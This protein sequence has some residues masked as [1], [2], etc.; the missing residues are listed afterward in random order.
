MRVDQTKMSL[1]WASRIDEDRPSDVRI[2]AKEKVDSER[3]IVWTTDERFEREYKWNRR[4]PR[5]EN[6]PLE[7]RENHP[8]RNSPRRFCFE[9]SSFQSMKIVIDRTDRF[10]R[11][12]STEKRSL[13][14]SIVLSNAPFTFNRFCSLSWLL[15]QGRVGWISKIR[16]F[17]LR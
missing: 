16:G 17:K 4:F 10:V 2:R 3:D 11:H 7:R 14:H 1:Y 15:D 6:K 13:V 5:E 12:R 9:H 8:V